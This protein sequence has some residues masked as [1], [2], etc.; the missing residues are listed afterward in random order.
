MR[1]PSA[2]D[3][4]S[5]E[6]RVRMTKLRQTIAPAP[7]GRAEHRRHADDVQRRRHERRHGRCARRT[8]TPSRRSTASKLGFMC[9]FVKAAR[10]GAEGRSRRQRRDRRARRSSTRTTTTSASRSAPTRASSC[11]WCATPTACRS[12]RSR[13]RSP[14]SAKRA[15]DGKLSHRA[16]CRAAP[17]PS[18]TAAS[19]ARSC[20]R[21]SSTPP[22]IAA[23]SACTRIKERPSCVN[24]QVVIRPMMYLALSYDHR[25]VDGT[26]GGDLPGA[27]QGSPG[28]SGAARA[29][30]VATPT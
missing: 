23:S 29:G 21:R 16:T 24:G 8:R 28:G 25:I 6:E 13:R 12:P 26:R 2:P 11:R 18:P 19:T 9:F 4:A 3:D 27:R 20:R 17:S 10:P 7:Q 22:Q 14:S 15:R 30:S 1:P 5:R